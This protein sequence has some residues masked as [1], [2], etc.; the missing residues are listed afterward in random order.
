MHG[1]ARDAGPWTKRAPMYA[2]FAGGG[3]M[4]CTTVTGSYCEL[5]HWHQ[6]GSSG[7]GTPVTGSVARNVRGSAT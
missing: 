6:I 3:W 4:L 1:R 2:T 5:W 7:F